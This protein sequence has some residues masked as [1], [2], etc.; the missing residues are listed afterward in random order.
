M[1]KTIERMVVNRTYKKKVK[2]LHRTGYQAINLEELKRYCSEYR[3]TKKT[4]RTLR[5]KKADILS[6]QPNEF[7]DYQQLKIQTTKQ[8]FHELEDF[9]DLF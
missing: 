6:I 9:S 1:F 8:S 3:W 4:V 2:E 5:E 7:F